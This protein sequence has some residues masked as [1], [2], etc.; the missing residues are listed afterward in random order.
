MGRDLRG[1]L[2]SKLL[3]TA[4]S[5]LNLDHIVQATLQGWKFDI[6]SGQ[7]VPMCNYHRKKCFHYFQISNCYDIFYIPVIH[8]LKGFSCKAD[9]CNIIM[10]CEPILVT[11]IHLIVPIRFIYRFRQRTISN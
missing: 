1:G 8:N 2:L 10:F 9:I 6:L 3:L 5:I 7:P 4:I 11:W